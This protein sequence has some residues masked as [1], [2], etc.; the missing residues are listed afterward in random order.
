MA[1]ISYGDAYAELEKSG[2]L[3]GSGDKIPEGEYVALVTRTN[4]RE[5]STKK[6]FGLQ[7]QVVEGEFADKKVWAN[8]AIIPSKPK[9]TQA[10]FITAEKFGMDKA[11]FSRLPAPSDSE[12]CQRFEGKTVKVKVVY[13]DTYQN[14]YINAVVSGDSVAGVPAQNFF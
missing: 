2:D 1:S 8:P 6:Q 5:D 3:G 10:F 14:V 12:V 7:L 4:V 9:V 11:F 13:R